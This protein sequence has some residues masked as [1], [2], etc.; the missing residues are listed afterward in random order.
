MRAE[1]LTCKLLEKH[2]ASERKINQKARVKEKTVEKEKCI[3]LGIF[4]ERTKEVSE[5]K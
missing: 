1:K 5:L 2:F 3:K 4:I